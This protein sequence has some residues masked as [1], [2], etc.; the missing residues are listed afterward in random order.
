MLSGISREARG[1]V[2]GATRTGVVCR[3]IQ[4]VVPAIFLPVRRSSMQGAE[5]SIGPE[6]AE[7]CKATFGRVYPWSGIGIEAKLSRA[8]QLGAW[9]A[10]IAFDPRQLNEYMVQDAYDKGYEDYVNR[11]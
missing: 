2:W 11:S 6:F 5:G 3:D 7:F 8:Y 10:S 1:L 9:H 4:R